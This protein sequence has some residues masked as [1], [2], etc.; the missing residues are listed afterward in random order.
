MLNKVLSN[1]ATILFSIF[2]IFTSLKAQTGSTD[3]V[4]FN[5]SLQNYVDELMVSFGKDAIRRERFLVKQIHL[6]N[7]EIKSRVGNVPNIHRSYF[8][9]LESRLNEVR[10]LKKR[11]AN[12]AS[13]SLTNFINDIEKEIR[14]TMRDGIID[15][16]RQKVIEEA[17]QLLYVAEE[18]IKLDPNASL[19]QDTKF[20]SKFRETRQDFVESFGKKE[21]LTQTT[22]PGQARATIFDLYEAWNYNNRLEYQLRWTDVEII[23]NRLI[24]NGSAEQRRRMFERE[25]YEAAEM[26]NLGFFDLAE[27]LFGE[28]IDRYKIMGSL[29]DCMFYK[30]EANYTLGRFSQAEK[31]FLSL[32]QRYPS[33]AYISDTYKRLMYIAFHF[34]KYDQVFDYLN[35]LQAIV[36]STDPQLDEVRFLAALAGLRSGRFDQTVSFGFEIPSSSPYYREVRYVMAEAYAGAGNFDEAL[37]FLNA[38]LLQK[39]I[40]PAFR[41]LVLLKIGYIN[42][43]LGQYA[44]AIRTFDRITG[45]SANYD[46][47]LIGY[48]W[49]YYKQELQKEKSDERN[50]T[51]ARKN[52]EVLIDLFYGS[53]YYLEA[54]TL[55]AYIYQLEQNTARAIQNFDYAYRSK[56]VK[57]LSN[58]LNQ[59]RSNL[60]SSVSEARSLE[61]RTLESNNLSA[62]SQ[63]Y[64]VRR[65]MERS[66]NDLTLSDLSGSGVATRNEIKLLNDQLQ[67]LD[68][69]KEIAEERQNKKLVDRITELQLRIYR[70]VNALSTTADTRQGFNYFDE[71]PFA[72][73]ESMIEHE[74]AMVKEMRAQVKTQKMEV[75]NRITQLNV[76]IG[77][78]K[79]R[80][81]YQ[82][83]IRLEI[84]RDRFTDLFKKLDALET[85]AFTFDIGDSRINVDEWSDYGAFG[86]ANVNFAVKRMKEQE[87]TTLLDQIDQINRLLENRKENIE[88]QID[89]I[90]TEIT[91]MMRRVREQERRREREEMKRRFEESY[92]DTHD[93]ELEYNPSTTTIPKVDQK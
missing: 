89:Q 15:F 56:D 55:L 74:N 9:R 91:I 18:M 60:L 93:S 10:A 48:A 51:M 70:T 21:D 30:G 68:R 31:D 80:R 6:L 64:E 71:H 76:E 37:S 77:N 83:M 79:S 12:V 63:A 69:L 38:L 88:H 40:D 39:G 13:Y 47:V 62:F 84:A 53:D 7:D 36:S 42:Y 72:R 17:V 32:M 19:E 20:S 61:S 46:R 11:L 4:R 49:S 59:E 3:M 58:R 81:D 85:H 29:D 82:K 16:K 5:A 50:F 27:R 57:A 33:S 24:K 78:A 67:E 14:N 45:T 87:I 35:R 41:S 92:F 52:L 22:P 43:E 8:E 73:K 44:A 28:I 1:S 66:I 34:E 26:F 75:T 90:V 2:L 23:K 54:K 86:M 65:K 25:L